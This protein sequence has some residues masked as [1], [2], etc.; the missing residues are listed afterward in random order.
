MPK[1]KEI[2]EQI[3]KLPIEL[4]H[5]IESVYRPESNIPTKLANH[6]LDFDEFNDKSNKDIA[7]HNIITFLLGNNTCSR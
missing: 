3:A 5:R 4:K 6:L 7:K 1:W 2:Y